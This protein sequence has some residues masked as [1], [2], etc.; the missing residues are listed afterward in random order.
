[1]ILDFEGITEDGAVAVHEVVG[2]MIVE[3]ETVTWI[4]NSEGLGMIVVHHSEMI[5]PTNE[6]G[7]IEMIV[8]EDVE[9]LHLRVE[10]GH[11]AIDPV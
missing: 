6:I 11:Q 7:G 8:L 2:V 9:H 10:V 4:G 3:I 1:M 5:E